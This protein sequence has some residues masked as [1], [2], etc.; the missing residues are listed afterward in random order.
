MKRP[1]K[2]DYLGTNQMGFQSE[3]NKYYDELERYADYLESKT[4]PMARELDLSKL[5]FDN[6]YTD[7][8]VRVIP[9][10]K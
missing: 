4:F 9:Y 10:K 2:N 5:D 6:S 1:N 3:L 7:D 8:D